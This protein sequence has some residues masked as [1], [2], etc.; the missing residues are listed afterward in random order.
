MW[1]VGAAIAPGLWDAGVPQAAALQSKDPRTNLRGIGQSLCRRGRPHS[2][3]S[4]VGATA[5][6]PESFLSKSKQASYWTIA[7]KKLNHN[8]H[9]FI[10]FKTAVDAVIRTYAVA[11][12]GAPPP[13]HDSNAMNSKSP[14]GVSAKICS[15][16]TVQA[17]VALQSKTARRSPR[18]RG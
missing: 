4:L 1:T 10:P 11:P 6:P 16:C 14:V 13:R 12:E 18:H 15:D 3:S 17:T 8:W 9:L 5:T 2:S 7:N